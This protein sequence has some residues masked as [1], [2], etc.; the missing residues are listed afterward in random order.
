MISTGFCN[1]K[2]IEYVKRKSGRKF[3]MVPL[4]LKPFVNDWVIYKRVLNQIPLF[5][6]V[7]LSLFRWVCLLSM[8][9]IKIVGKHRPESAQSDWLSSL[10]WRQNKRRT[11]IKRCLESRKLAPETLRQLHPLVSEF[12]KGISWHKKRRFHR[13]ETSVQ[14]PQSLET[15]K[16]KVVCRHDNEV[17]MPLDYGR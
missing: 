7:K 1:K 11:Y 10:N 15:R 16:D 5:E 4:A 2:A 8:N 12:V 3:D 6:C 17:K 9:A 13:L 14:R